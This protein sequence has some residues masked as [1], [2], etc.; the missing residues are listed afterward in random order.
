VTWFVGRINLPVVDARHHRQIDAV[1]RTIRFAS[2][3]FA[4]FAKLFTTRATMKTINAD[5]RRERERC[6]FDPM[7]LTH[8]WDGNPEK[9]AQRHE[10][11][12]S[13]HRHIHACIY[14]FTHIAMITGTTGICDFA[15]VRLL[16]NEISR[17]AG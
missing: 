5:L 4:R 9:T 13:L 2:R 8:F 10:L 3:E 7:E 1:E 14:A 16:T 15:F 17:S 6:S 12:A 11:G